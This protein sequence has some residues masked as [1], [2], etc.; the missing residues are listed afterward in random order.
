MQVRFDEIP[1]EGWRLEIKDESWF[2]D[3]EL[4]RNKDVIV[5]V[6]LKKKG[7]RILLNGAFDTELKFNCDRCLETF[8]HPFDI[9]FSV[10]IELVDKA[11]AD[12]QIE[13]HLC[14]EDEMDMVYLEK[15]VIDIFQV[16]R[17]QAILA[18]PA[19]KLCSEDCKGLCEKCGEN[20]NLKNCG[21][22]PDQ[23]SSPFSLLRKLKH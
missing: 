16:L 12:I 22:G 1:L 18:I 2:P 14:G 11:L 21:C 15:P 3:Q 13:D 17:Q 6:F 10:E 5:S 4:T 7:E 8:I 9:D 19:K 20:L 23:S